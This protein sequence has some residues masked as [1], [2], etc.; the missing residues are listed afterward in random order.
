[1][2]DWI[3]QI[4]AMGYGVQLFVVPYMKAFAPLRQGLSI[5]IPESHHSHQIFVEKKYYYRPPTT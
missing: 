5:P 1:M 4:G 3:R 2:F